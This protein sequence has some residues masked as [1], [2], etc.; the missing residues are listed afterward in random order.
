ML[1]LILEEFLSFRFPVTLRLEAEYIAEKREHEAHA[2]PEKI[3]LRPEEKPH[4]A[5]MDR[6][7][8]DKVR[9][10]IR[11][12]IEIIKPSEDIVDEVRDIAPKRKEPSVI[13]SDVSDGRPRRVIRRHLPRIRDDLKIRKL[14]IKC[15]LKSFFHC[16]LGMERIESLSACIMECENNVIL[17][18]VSDIL[19]ERDDVR[20]LR[21]DRVIDLDEIGFHAS[22]VRYR[23]YTTRSI[24][25]FSDS[26]GFSCFFMMT[27]QK[28]TIIQREY[29]PLP[30]DFFSVTLLTIHSLGTFRCV[31][32]DHIL[33][34]TITLALE[35]LS[36]IPLR[37]TVEVALIGMAF[38]DR[39][40]MLPVELEFLPDDAE[41]F[42]GHFTFN[43]PVE[44][45]I[46]DIFDVRW[47][48]ACRDNLF[49]LRKWSFVVG[50]VEDGSVKKGLA[51]APLMKG[52]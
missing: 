46:G 26:Q 52:G 32:G 10:A 11:R 15:P 19:E 36:R 22:R 25:I 13:E 16:F 23:I 6:M 8:T 43:S 39:E 18:D 51:L 38:W 28:K 31:R 14:R 20:L 41:W 49:H 42:L 27:E 30:Y 3:P 37:H 21:G 7:E 45:V 17:E 2:E 35:E 29:V 40:I 50:P 48:F 34:T 5:R 1:D 44:N 24:P 9:D 12:R 47:K 4:V 33:V